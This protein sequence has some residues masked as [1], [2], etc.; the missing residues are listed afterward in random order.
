MFLTTYV[1]SWFKRAWCKKAVNSARQVERIQHFTHLL[2]DP[3]R[4]A[5]RGE[6]YLSQCFRH[7]PWTIR[8]IK[9]V[10]KKKSVSWLRLFYRLENWIP[11]I[12]KSSKGYPMCGRHRQFLSGSGSLICLI[13]FG[14][15]HSLTGCWLHC[16]ER[17]CSS[18]VT[19]TLL[20]WAAAKTLMYLFYL[21]LKLRWPRGSENPQRGNSAQVFAEGVWKPGFAEAPRNPKNVSRRIPHFNHG[22]VRGSAAEVNCSAGPSAEVKTVAAEVAQKC[23]RKTYVGMKHNKTEVLATA[24][25][26]SLNFGCKYMFNYL[27]THPAESATYWVFVMIEITLFDIVKTFS[28]HRRLWFMIESLMLLHY[29]WPGRCLQR[30]WQWTSATS[31]AC[32]ESCTAGRWRFVP[33]RAPQNDKPGAIQLYA[34]YLIMILCIWIS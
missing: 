9:E 14:H 32:S 7:A 34:L 4:E 33:R 3:N 22:H 15:L 2:A 12:L 24:H 20:T 10:T 30:V 19:S 11:K 29:P 1:T 25:H 27:R 16:M 5:E 28:I 17:Q 6:V 18:N 31:F 13:F 8:V 21:G 26:S 23:S